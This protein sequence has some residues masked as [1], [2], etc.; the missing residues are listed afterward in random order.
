[1]KANKRRKTTILMWFGHK[2]L[3]PQSLYYSLIAILQPQIIPWFL[4]LKK[5]KKKKPMTNTRQTNK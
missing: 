5:K 2:S 1:M 4:K 3:H